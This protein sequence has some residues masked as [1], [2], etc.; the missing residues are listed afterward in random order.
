V[1]TKSVA[2]GS[3]YGETPKH[4]AERLSAPL[5]EANKIQA[6]FFDKSPGI[7]DVYWKEVE[8]KIRQQSY[9]TSFFGRKRRFWLV[10]RENW[11]DILKEGYNFDPQATASDLNLRALIRL[12][13]RFGDEVKFVVT[14]HDQLMAEIHK[15]VLD[16]AI[17][18]IVTVMED[19]PELTVPTPVEIKIGRRW[20]SL[21]EHDNTTR[22]SSYA[23]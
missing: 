20:G 15:D 1:T 2:Y 3:A 11:K 17:R 21:G 8:Q 14:V 6:D 5:R 9:L 12:N 16:E 13:G 23:S 22:A 19:N 4:L 10:T 7:K 18:T